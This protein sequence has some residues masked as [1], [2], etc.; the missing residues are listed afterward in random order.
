MLVLTRNLGQKIMIDGNAITVSVLGVRG[1]Q[2]QIGIQAP[3]TT[4]VHREEIY[5]KIKAEQ[6]S[7]LKIKGNANTV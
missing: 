6:N 5:Q 1:N 2:V 7:G 3:R 4:S